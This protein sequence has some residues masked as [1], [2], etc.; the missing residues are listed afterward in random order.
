MISPEFYGAA[1]TE[2]E[3]KEAEAELRRE[4]AENERLGL[5][6]LPNRSSD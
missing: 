2:F 4:E 1:V 5:R 6:R 3:M